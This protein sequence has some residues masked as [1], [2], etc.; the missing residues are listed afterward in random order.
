MLDIY[1]TIIADGPLWGISTLFGESAELGASDVPDIGC[2]YLVSECILSPGAL[3]M[4]SVLSFIPSL[5]ARQNRG[6]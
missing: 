5:R 1:L 3:D 2:T 6:L 4:R